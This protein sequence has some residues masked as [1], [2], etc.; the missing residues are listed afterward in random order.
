V[1]VDGLGAEGE[2]SD[3]GGLECSGNSGFKFDEWEGGEVVFIGTCVQVGEKGDGL[4][5]FRE[6]LYTIM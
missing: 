3:M 4:T 1:G 5:S 2:R 6:L